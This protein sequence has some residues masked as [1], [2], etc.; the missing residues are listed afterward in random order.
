MVIIA[1]D[2][3]SAVLEMWRYQFDAKNPQP[4]DQFEGFPQT[5]R[6]GD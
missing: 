6:F 5:I 1:P 4:G 3:K 2:R